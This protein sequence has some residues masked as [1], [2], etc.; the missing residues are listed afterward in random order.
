L[1]KWLNGQ[2]NDASINLP[3]RPVNAPVSL[4]FPQQR[5]LFLELFEPNTAVNNPLR[6]FKTNR[7]G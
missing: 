3:R 5:Q 2:L 1:E 4:S 6:F 7:S